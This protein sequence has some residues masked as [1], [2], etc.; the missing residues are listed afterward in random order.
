MNARLRRPTRLSF[1]QNEVVMQFKAMKL[2]V[3]CAALML[4]V[5][6]KSSSDASSNSAD[7]ANEPPPSGTGTNTPPPGSNDG[8]GRTHQGVCGCKPNELCVTESTTNHMS[9][10]PDVPCEPFDCTCFTARG[11]KDPCPQDFACVSTNWPLVT[12]QRVQGSKP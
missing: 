12:C 10:A 4:C 6:C 5:G 8:A 7:D 1:R 11:H 2:G 9:C 3:A